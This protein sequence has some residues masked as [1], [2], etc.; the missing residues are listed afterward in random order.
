MNI[1]KIKEHIDDVLIETNFP[2]LGEKK[3]GKVRDIY[4]ARDH[5]T[6][7]STDRHSSFDRNIAYILLKGKF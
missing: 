1:E 4:I 5:V 3:V 2:E 7:I 6:L